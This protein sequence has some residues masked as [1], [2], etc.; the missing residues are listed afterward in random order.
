MKNK[1]TAQK[2][3]KFIDSKLAVECEEEAHT[4][5]PWKAIYDRD[6]FLLHGFN[7]DDHNEPLIITD[8]EEPWTIA[9]IAGG[10]EGN[11][12]EQKANASFIV[13]ACNSHEELLEVLKEVEKDTRLH[14]RIRLKTHNLLRQTISKAE[15]AK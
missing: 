3:N 11:L 1:Q 15:G 6:D 8:E 2:M 13:R 12:I 4:A 5:T 10:L 14:G 7:Y 9:S